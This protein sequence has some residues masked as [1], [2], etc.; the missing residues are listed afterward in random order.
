MDKEAK[1]TF[2]AFQPIQGILERSPQLSATNTEIKSSLLRTHS[3][4]RSPHSSRGCKHLCKNLCSV[5]EKLYTT[6]TT[7]HDNTHVDS[8][9]QTNPAYT[10][11]S[12][13]DFTPRC[14][15]MRKRHSLKT[16][17]TVCTCWQCFNGRLVRQLSKLICFSDRPHTLM[18]Q[19]EKKT[20]S[21]KTLHTF[22]TCWQCLDGRPVWQL[23]KLICF[24]HRLHIPMSQNEKKT[25]YFFT[26]TYPKLQGSLGHHRWLHNQLPP[27]YPV[28]HCPLALGELQA[29]PFPDY[30]FNCNTFCRVHLDLS[31][32]N[33]CMDLGS[34]IR[35]VYAAWNVLFF[36]PICNPCS[37]LN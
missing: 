7:E 6:C 23:S 8:N 29:C 11:L 16:L 22:C 4:Q 37:R 26:F 19:N 36:L 18:S 27:F 25:D 10:C 1:E 5:L 20:H 33:E 12:A 21:L 28:L 30:C 3:C 35:G 34:C 13:I 9:F 2:S 24:S 31:V 14:H 32:Y 17:H 15:K